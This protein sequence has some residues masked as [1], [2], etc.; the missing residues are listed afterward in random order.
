[1]KETFKSANYKYVKYFGDK[2]HI[3]KDL[4]QNKFEIFRSNKN[5]ASW[6]LKYKNT[7]LEFIRS[8]NLTSFFLTF[9]CFFEY[10][11]V[12]LGKSH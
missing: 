5:H 6:G 3:V 11:F 1:M 8:L 12:S 9:C 7:H 10:L 2:V 4:T